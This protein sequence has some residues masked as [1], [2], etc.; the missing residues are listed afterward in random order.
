MKPIEVIYDISVTLGKGAVDWPGL[1]PYCRELISEMKAGAPCDV[2]RLDIVCHVGT[3]VDTP[4]HFVPGGKTMDEYPIGRWIVP[5]QVDSIKDNEAI[6]SSELKHLD[7]RPGEAVL[8]RTENSRIGRVASGVFS[9]EYVYI[10]LEAAD[11][12]IS[13]KVG[14][15]GID[16]AGVDSFP[17]GEAPVHKRLLGADILLLEG[18][19]LKDVPEGRYTFFCLPLKVS[20]AEGSPARAVLVR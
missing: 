14:L 17:L 7:I 2:S 9:E 13:K 12:L 3:H 10:S 4:A 20:G 16:Y 19:N 6:R 15:L 11:F 1:P 8:F 18:I 5:T